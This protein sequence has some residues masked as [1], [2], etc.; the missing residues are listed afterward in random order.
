[1]PR[2]IPNQ[3]VIVII[4]PRRAPARHPRMLPGGLR[5][6]PDEK[7]LIRPVALALATPCKPPS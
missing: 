7:T 2:S 4:L 5:K 3:Y 6:H 1:V